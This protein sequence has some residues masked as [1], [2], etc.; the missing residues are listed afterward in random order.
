MSS[1]ATQHKSPFHLLFNIVP[2]YKF[3]RPFGCA[4]FPCIHPYN[5]HKLSFRSSKC[6]FLGYN[7]RHKGYHYL[8]PSGRIYISNTVVF[9]ESEF[10]YTRLFPPPVATTPQPIITQPFYLPPT[11][12]SSSSSTPTHTHTDQPPRSYPS[13]Q[14][15]SSSLS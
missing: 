11:P 5:K 14:N 9:L 15:Q 1:P 10:P 13:L 7:S 6:I 12:T 8:H 4:Y 3:L 2:D